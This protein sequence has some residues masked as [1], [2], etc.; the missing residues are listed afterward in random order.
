MFIVNIKQKLTI[1][2]WWNYSSQKETDLSFY[3]LEKTLLS[4]QKVLVRKL[5]VISLNLNIHRL[6]RDNFSETI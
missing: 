4:L 2:R 3:E 6:I 5:H 1:H